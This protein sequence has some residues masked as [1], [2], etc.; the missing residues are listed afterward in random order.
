VVKRKLSTAFHP[1]TD[2]QLE[3]LNK[4]VE[5]YL[6]AFTNLEQ[7]NWAKLLPT[8]IY[9]YNNSLNHILKMTPFKA[10]YGYD[11]DF[12]IDVEGDVTG[13]AP[14][15]LDRVNKLEGLTQ[16]PVGQ[17]PSTP[18]KVLRPTSHTS[19]IQEREPCQIVYSKFK[20][21]GQETPAKVHWTISGNRAHWQSGLSVSAI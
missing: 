11:P 15:A 12:H 19:G 9:A 1:K 3:I 21:E 16:G 13:R 2:G 10:M 6:R 17:S 7:M 8:A 14:A 5:N 20:T 18:E 4:I